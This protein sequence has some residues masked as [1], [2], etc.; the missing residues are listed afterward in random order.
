MVSLLS[1]VSAQNNNFKPVTNEMLL[2]P[3]ANDWLMNGRTHDQTRY[4]PLDQINRNNV[5]TLDLVWSR[6][7]PNGTTETIPIV[8]DGIMYVIS[9]NNSVVEL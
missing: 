6:G 7:L 1:V 9:P 4:S 8:Y 2:N 5:N 3:N